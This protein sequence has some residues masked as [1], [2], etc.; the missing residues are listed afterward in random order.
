MTVSRPGSA[1]GRCRLGMAG[2][3]GSD[4][5]TTLLG[6]EQ[7]LAIAEATLAEDGARLITLLGTGGI[8]KTRLAIELARRAR[9]QDRTVA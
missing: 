9:H 4:P 8:G 1:G 6:R 2:R 7:D 5:P 3:H